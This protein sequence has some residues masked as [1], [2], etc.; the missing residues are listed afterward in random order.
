MVMFLIST[1]AK[2][3]CDRGTCTVRNVDLF[4][5]VNKRGLDSE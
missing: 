2:T 1:R 4:Q 5:I 3:K